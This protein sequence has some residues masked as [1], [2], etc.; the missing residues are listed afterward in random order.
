MWPYVVA[1]GVAAVSIVLAALQQRLA[2]DLLRRDIYWA[3]D[4]MTGSFL[5]PGRGE[6]YAWLWYLFTL[7]WRRITEPTLRARCRRWFLIDAMLQAPLW[8]FAAYALY[9]IA[10]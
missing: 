10:R 2:R 5:V 1:G 4:R 3:P 9:R 8:A 6:Y 7:R